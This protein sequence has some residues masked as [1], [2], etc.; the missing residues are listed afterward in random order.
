MRN[1][2]QVVV[3]ATRRRATHRATRTQR[4]NRPMFFGFLPIIFRGTFLRS[5]RKSIPKIKELI[6]RTMIV[7]QPN[8]EAIKEMGDSLKKSRLI[9]GTRVRAFIVSLKSKFSISPTAKEYLLVLLGLETRIS[10]IPGSAL[11]RYSDHCQ[12]SSYPNF[13][14]IYFHSVPTPPRVARGF[15]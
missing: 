11:S 13:S 9:C 15:A 12:Y 4:S 3:I 1:T 10:Y 7:H 14:N 5:S 8:G 2:L 6:N